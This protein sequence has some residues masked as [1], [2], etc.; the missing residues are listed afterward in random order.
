MTQGRRVIRFVGRGGCVGVRPVN[1][2]RVSSGASSTPKISPL[3][4][5]YRLREPDSALHAQ[6]LH[7]ICLQRSTYRI[8][9]YVWPARTARWLVYRPRSRRACLPDLSGTL[10]DRIATIATYMEDS[11]KKY[12]NYPHAEQLVR[13]FP[14]EAID[15]I[16]RTCEVQEIVG[17]VS[18]ACQKSGRSLYEPSSSES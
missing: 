11:H 1:S 5:P 18:L 4:H 15:L 16:A 6:T 2:G 13:Q 17:S 3:L 12:A 9:Q 14:G 8:W 7:Q 10:A